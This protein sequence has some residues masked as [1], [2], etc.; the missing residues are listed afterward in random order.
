[1]AGRRLDAEVVVPLLAECVD[2]VGVVVHGLGP[3]DLARPSVL[4]GWSVRDLAAHLVVV[5]DSVLHLEALPSTAGVLS[6]SEYLAGYATRAE[7]IT[8]LTQ[9][10]AVEIVDLG[11]AYDERWEAALHHLASFAGTEKV[12][13]RRAA[14]RTADFVATRVIELVVH[15]DD[16]ARSVTAESV[17]ADDL[18]RS[19]TAE[20][21]GAELPAAAEKLVARVLL[22][23]LASRH[24]GR[25]VE[26][27]V[28]PV[29][30]IQCLP[31]PRHSRGTPANVVETDQLT[32]VR[33]AAGR[34]DWTDAVADGRV[35]ASGQRADLSMVM[36]LL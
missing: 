30:A 6:I 8:G 10:A 20:S 22:D 14:A 5:A 3:V 11:A 18:A 26:V 13:A 34:V 24:P 27:R 2:A 9:E 21:V 17:G 1:V 23:V 19:V 25:S 33:L 28:P 29:A 31:G 4:P 15:A 16:L 36:P 7:R 32:W 12:L 35:S